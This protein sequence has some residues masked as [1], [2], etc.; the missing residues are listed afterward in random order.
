MLAATCSAVARAAGA[1]S[2][3]HRDSI[4]SVHGYPDSDACA[5]ACTLVRAIARSCGSACRYAIPDALADAIARANLDSSANSYPR[6]RAHSGSR[7][8]T[9]ACGVCSCG[10]A[11]HYAIPNALAGFPTYGNPFAY[12]WSWLE[13]SEH[14]PELGRA[15]SAV[16]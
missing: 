8:S 12:L 13:G 11:N 16:D 14:T 15:E 3:T 5:D 9:L 7:D 10:D 6:A 1:G 4:A 2:D